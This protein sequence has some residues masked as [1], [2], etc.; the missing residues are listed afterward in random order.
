MPEDLKLAAQ[1]FDKESYYKDRQFG[2]FSAIKVFSKCETLFRDIFID[3]TYEEPEQDY[4]IYG[5]LVDALVTEKPEFIPK[6]FVRVER[7]VKPEDALKI[8]NQIKALDDEIKAKE[9]ELQTKF[10]AKRKVIEDKI[11]T[12]LAKET[13]TGANITALE[14]LQSEMK[15]MTEYPDQYH[16]KTIVKGIASRREEVTSLRISLNM[17]AEYADKQQVTNS[18]WENAEET[19]LALKT[20]PSYSNM[21]F[22]EVT[23]QQ[24]FV[25]IIDGIPV[26]GKLDHLH[27]SPA[28]TKIYAIYIA[29]QITLDQLQAKIREMNPNDL[30]GIITDI[31]TCKSVAELEPYNN[32][33]RGQLGFYQDL[34]SATLLIPKNQIRCRILVADKLSST[35]KKA[36]LFEYTQEAL[37][38]LK[39]DVWAWVKLWWNA[40]QNRSYVSAKAKHGMAQKCYTCTECRFCPF[41]TSPGQPVMINGPRFGAKGEP[42]TSLSLDV[43]TADAV[44]DY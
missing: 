12:L 6:Y 11:A 25:T 43:S 34:V 35:F 1:L 17:I 29:K 41:S 24:V 3:R 19:A 30:W 10:D 42:A 15:E 21:E 22:N 40:V 36:E 18:I 27:L 38:E 13:K 23:S 26:K 28:L 39:G 2:S 4:F 20:H 8:E 31:K 16:D 5:K 14:K 37:D 32:H 33:Y 44:L 7:K 9:A